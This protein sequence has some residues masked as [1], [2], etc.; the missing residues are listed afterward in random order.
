MLD[1]K[2][3]AY[4]DGLG[5]LQATPGAAALLRIRRGGAVCAARSSPTRRAPT[6]T[7]CS[8]RIGLAERLP[9]VVIGGELAR[10]KPDPLPY[11]TAWSSPARA[12]DALG[13]FEDSLSGV[14]RG[15]GAGI[16]VVGLTTG[17]SAERLVGAGA[18]FAVADFTDRAHLR[19]DRRFGNSTSARRGRALNFTWSKA[20]FCRNLR[21]SSECSA[22]WSS[23]PPRFWPLLPGR[24][25]A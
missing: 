3:A 21:V 22:S 23:P 16:A 11:L 19:V 1:A 13:R 17:L 10:S 4:R 25:L 5:A 24:G 20:T 12:A 8:R 14:R 2:E 15:R 18:A 6:R 7:R 9:I